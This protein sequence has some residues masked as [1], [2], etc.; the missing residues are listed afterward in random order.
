MAKAI[1]SRLCFEYSSLIQIAYFYW[2]VTLEALSVFIKKIPAR[3]VQRLG[4]FVPDSTLSHCRTH[5][6]VKYFSFHWMLVATCKLC[7]SGTAPPARILQPLW[8]TH[9]LGRFYGCPEIWPETLVKH[10]LATTTHVP[11]HQE[12][13]WWPGYDSSQWCSPSSHLLHLTAATP[14]P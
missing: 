2:I 12:S 10:Q 13:L 8:R 14:P 6:K 5:C 3:G 1:L 11:S 7:L 4:S 9:V